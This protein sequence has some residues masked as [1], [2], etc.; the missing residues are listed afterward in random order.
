MVSKF[1]KGGIAA[2][3]A[4]S[5]TLPGVA[6]AAETRSR[7][8]LPV[9]SGKIKRSVPVATGTRSEAFKQVPIWAIVGGV[10]TIVGVVLIATDG[11]SDG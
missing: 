9:V 11:D 6:S 4:I 2:L 5:L 3:M 1:F 8:A 10:L 7:D